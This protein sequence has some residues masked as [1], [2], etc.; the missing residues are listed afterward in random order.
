MFIG[1]FAIADIAADVFATVHFAT[2]VQP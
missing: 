2:I 1:L